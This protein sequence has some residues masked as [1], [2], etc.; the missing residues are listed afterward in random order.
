V[1]FFVVV[2][3]ATNQRPPVDYLQVASEA[4]GAVDVTLAAPRLPA[5]WSANRAELDQKGSDGIVA[6]RVGLVTPGNQYI[7]IDQGI[8]ANPSW[9]AA[10]LAGTASTGSTTIDGTTWQVYDRRGVSDPGNIAYALVAT[11]P[12]A[13]GGA[14]STIVLSGTAPDAEFATL[15]SAII[16]QVAP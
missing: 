9:V 6:W 1:I 14:P 13:G 11:I 15:A 3:P 2:R 4:Q 16:D 10:L 7:A 12:A 5:G 8:G